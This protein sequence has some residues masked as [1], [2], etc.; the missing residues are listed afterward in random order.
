MTAAFA[1][2]RSGG[3][4]QTLTMN[5]ASRF[6]LRDGILR[7]RDALFPFASIECR[8]AAEAVSVKS[9]EWA[10][11]WAKRGVCQAIMNLGPAAR[12]VPLH[13]LL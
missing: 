13:L 10:T 4:D 5:E 8:G 1:V 3:R 9:L 6:C 2:S 11:C 7:H 12:Q